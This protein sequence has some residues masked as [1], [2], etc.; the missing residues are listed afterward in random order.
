MK[1][2]KKS[3]M[4]TSFVIMSFIMVLGIGS[5]H[6][7]VKC[8]SGAITFVGVFPDLADA[9]TGASPYIIQ[10]VCDNTTQMPG[11]K[12]FQLNNDLGESGYATVLTAVSLGQ[13]VK[14]QAAGVGW[15]ALLER[16]NLVLQ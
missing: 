12:Q 6:A 5:S 1:K 16:I 15:N 14:I 7:S 11:T 10:Y 8:D 13:K 9:G 3:R 4:V 2:I